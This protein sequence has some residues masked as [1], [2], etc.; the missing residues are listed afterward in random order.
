MDTVLEE[1]LRREKAGESYVMVTVVRA[2]APTSAMVGARALVGPGNEITGYIGG[3]CTRRTVLEIAGEALVDGHPRLVLLSS[4]PRLNR[5]QEVDGC[6]LRPMTCDSGG[7]I[8]LF[9]EPKLANPVLL[10]VGNSPVSHYLED[11][12]KHLPFQVK[13]LATLH[14]STEQDKPWDV[15]A[16]ELREQT[17]HGGFVVVCTMG[18]YDD[19][20]IEQIG[21][22]PIFYLGIVSSPKRGEVLR[23]RIREMRPAQDDLNVSIPAGW[24]LHTREPAEIAVSILAEVI[25]TRRQM[26]LPKE[27]PSLLDPPRENELAWVIDPVC[28]MRVNWYETPYRTVYNGEKRGFCQA[29]CR[30]A[31]LKDPEKYGSAGL[32]KAEEG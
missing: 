29:S 12:A 1:A 27:A 18:Q 6:L 16:E 19:W 30:D 24:D 23:G 11:M 31:F 9:V 32:E 7:T 15:L 10:V 8:E 13:S 26:T 5:D 14:D 17:A 20:V 21:S 25:A 4:D 3:E 22:A 2:Q 28:Q